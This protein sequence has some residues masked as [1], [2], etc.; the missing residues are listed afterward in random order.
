MQENVTYLIQNCRLAPAADASLHAII[1]DLMIGAS[2]LT[3]EGHSEE[4]LAKLRDALSE[5]PRLFN[6]PN[7]DPLPA[8][9]P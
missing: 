1:N 7:W 6:H 9:A 3:T 8:P 2:L 4:G 5:Y